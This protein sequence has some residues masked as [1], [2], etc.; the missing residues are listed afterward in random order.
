METIVFQSERRNN[1]FSPFSPPLFSFP[2]SGSRLALVNSSPFLSSC[3]V[4][5]VA[6]WVSGGRVG[7]SPLPPP[8]WGCF[9]IPAHDCR[10]FPWVPFQRFALGRRVG[11]CWR[12][13]S[14]PRLGFLPLAPVAHLHIFEGLRRCS[15][16]QVGTCW[17]RSFRTWRTF[18]AT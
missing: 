18:L 12:V 2:P 9:G 15:F 4:V 14:R 11:W 6:G 8:F 10:D 16:C 7:A 3:A 17:V 1:F 13:G 5:S